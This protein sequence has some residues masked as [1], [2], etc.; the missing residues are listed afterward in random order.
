M[1]E[2]NDEMYDNFYTEDEYD[3][4]GELTDIENC[5]FPQPVNFDNMTISELIQETQFPRGI[6]SCCTATAILM[7]MNEGNQIRNIPDENTNN[8]NIINEN[9]DYN[10]NINFQIRNI[11]NDIYE[12]MISRILNSGNES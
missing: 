1:C 7:N 11:D 2:Q 4:Y 12:D 10:Y 6:G 8:Y 5:R 9:N 3:I